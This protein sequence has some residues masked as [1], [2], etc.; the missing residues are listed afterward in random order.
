MEE[1]ERDLAT[2]KEVSR[3]KETLHKELTTKMRN[4]LDTVEE[5]WLKVINQ[6]T[7]V[8]E[9]FRARSLVNWEKLVKIREY[10]G[11]LEKDYRRIKTEHDEL[12]EQ[13]ESLQLERNRDQMRI[14]ELLG[15]MQRQELINQQKYQE[16]LEFEKKMKNMKDTIKKE[17]RP[18]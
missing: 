16:Q 13:T 11:I 12:F 2:I 17:I 7:M 6:N 8:A 3:T 10:V 4:E 9:D 5:R 15:E 1:A 18:Y 14:E